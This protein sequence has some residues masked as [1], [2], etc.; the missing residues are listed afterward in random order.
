VEPRTLR[1]VVDDS[2]AG[3]EYWQYHGNVLRP[4]RDGLVP[5]DELLTKKWEACDTRKRI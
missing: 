2:L 1:I 4:R 5:S 3:T